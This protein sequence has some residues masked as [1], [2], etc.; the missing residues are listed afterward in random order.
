[1]LILGDL[2]GDVT[3][4][5]E[6]ISSVIRREL[7]VLGT[8]NSKITPAG[9]SEWEMVVAHIATGQLAGGPADQ[10][11]GAAGRWRRGT[12]AD[13]TERRTWSNKVLFA[14]S[15][16]AAPRPSTARRCAVRPGRSGP[17]GSAGSELRR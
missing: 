8:W 16:Q 3:I 4:P 17:N 11:C 7:T 10:S 1:M 6:L 14:V 2:K 9:R 13:M 12:F 5:R 15:A